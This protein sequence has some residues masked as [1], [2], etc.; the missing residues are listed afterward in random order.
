MN[1]RLIEALRAFNR[2]QKRQRFVE[3]Q[4]KT[5]ENVAHS[6]TCS[7][8]E[9]EV[10]SRTAR[11]CEMCGERLAEIEDTAFVSPFP[12]A[13]KSPHSASDSEG[14]SSEDDDEDENEDEDE[15][16]LRGGYSDEARRGAR[17]GGY[18]MRSGESQKLLRSA[19]KTFRETSRRTAPRK[20]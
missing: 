5:D 15:R 13:M 9:Y 11:M 20:A 6:R 18:G 3:D 10:T 17:T 16:R 4:T 2:S 14:Y 8:C 7:A 12:G 19:L 1:R